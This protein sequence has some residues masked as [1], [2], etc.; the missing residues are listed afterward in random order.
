MGIPLTLML[1]SAGDGA[2]VTLADPDPGDP[3][4]LRDL[5]DLCREAEIVV[6]DVSVPGLV[7]AEWISPG[8]TVVDVGVSRVDGRVVGDVDLVSVQAVAGAIC[9]NPGGAGPMTVACLLQNTL[10]AARSVG[11]GELVG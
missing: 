7:T 1:S 3:G 5:A 11:A 2:V 4:A 8:A 6:S 10:A 9:P